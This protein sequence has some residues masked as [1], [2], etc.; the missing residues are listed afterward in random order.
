MPQE[1][2]MHLCVAVRRATNPVSL[3]TTRMASCQSIAFLVPI[4]LVQIFGVTMVVTGDPLTSAEAAFALWVVVLIL[5]PIVA[6]V[7]YCCRLTTKAS[8]ELSLVELMKQVTRDYQDTLSFHILRDAS[9][10]REAMQEKIDGP[11]G[12]VYISSNYILRIIIMDTEHGTG[13]VRHEDADAATRL[14][15]LGGIQEVVSKQEH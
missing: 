8:V 1:D 10:T 6:C 11:W 14:E 3:Y 2:W 4:A 12:R 13:Y 9:D 5:W 7:R 15:Q